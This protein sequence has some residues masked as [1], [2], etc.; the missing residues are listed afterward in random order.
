MFPVQQTTELTKCRK[1]MAVMC[2]I[3]CNVQLI[4]PAEFI[5]DGVK[6]GI[7]EDLSRNLLSKRII[8]EE[9]FPSI[10]SR[11]GKNCCRDVKKS[12]ESWWPSLLCLMTLGSNMDSVGTTVI[13]PVLF[14]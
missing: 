10:Q 13:R 8:C 1:S 2:Y 12:E 5:F 7:T 4:S 9:Y 3:S 11:S 6:G 14:Y